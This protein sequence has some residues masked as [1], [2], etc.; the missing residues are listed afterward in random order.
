MLLVLAGVAAVAQM[1]QPFSAD[2]NTVNAHG[3][4]MMGKLYFSAPKMRMDVTSQEA[5]AN[6]PMGKVS[7]I[8]DGSAKTVIM[9]MPQQ[10]MYMEISSAGSGPDM[11][12]IE[13]LQELSR[14]ADPCMGE[15]G[16]TCKKLGSETVNGRSCD[17]WDTTDKQGHAATVW[18][19]QKLHFPI[20]VQEKDGTVTNFTNIKE[21]ALD[22]SLFV[23]PPGYR[24]F[25]ASAYGRQK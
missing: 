17:K 7:V 21:G 12:G 5:K 2:V 19:D 18:I 23:I 20:K 16:M 6:N 3:P 4:V 11:E 15:T 14:G 10:Q 24:K 9:L 8:I 13:R 1:P 22:A 25:D